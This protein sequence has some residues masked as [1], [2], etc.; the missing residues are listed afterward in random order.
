MR[1]LVLDLRGNPGGQ[2]AMAIPVARSLVTE[3]LTLGTMQFRDFS[4]TLTAR[5]EWA[6][7]RSPGRS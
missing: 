3:P 4:Q 1:A 2:G 6:S 7:S 5:P